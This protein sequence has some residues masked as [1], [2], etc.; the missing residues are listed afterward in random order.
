MDAK[1]L[2]AAAGIDLD[3]AKKWA[4]PLTKAM[5]RFGIDSPLRQAMFIAQVGH[6]SGGF[7]ALTENLNYSAERLV[8]VWPHRFSAASAAAVARKP[9]QVANVVYANRMGN[10]Q[11]G[12][13]WR[14]R[15]RGL[16]QLTGRQNYTRAAAALGLPLVDNPDLLAEP[17]AAAMAAAWYWADRGLNTWAD[18]N[19]VTTVTRKINGGLTGLADRQSR[20]AVA[21]KALGA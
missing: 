18:L 11:A 9:E 14:Y 20:L 10:T 4:S 19:D 6:E 21:R 5:D 17:E 2:A 7:K 15:G 16:V 12:D 13:G 3:T 1:T 8:A